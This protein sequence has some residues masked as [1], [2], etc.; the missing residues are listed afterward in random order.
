MMLILFANNWICN[1][2]LKNSK[3]LLLRT[4]FIYKYVELSILLSATTLV[5]NSKCDLNVISSYI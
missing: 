5:V 2:D 1:N 3:F 4:Y